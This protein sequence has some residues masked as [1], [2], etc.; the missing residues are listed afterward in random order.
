MAVRKWSSIHIFFSFLILHFFLS[1]F[2][3]RQ[4]KE[5]KAKDVSTK[6]LKSDLNKTIA[7]WLILVYNRR[8]YTLAFTHTHSLIRSGQKGK[9]KDSGLYYTHTYSCCIFFLLLRNGV[10]SR[11]GFS[12][13]RISYPP[14]PLSHLYLHTDTLWLSVLSL[15]P[16]LPR[17]DV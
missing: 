10:G 1:R 13:R 14:S 3:N 5:M 12:R 9:N 4:R 2:G 17:V 16:R 6:V 7:W 11:V 8:I 15:I